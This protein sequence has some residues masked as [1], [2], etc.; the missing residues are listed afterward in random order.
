MGTTDTDTCKRELVIEVP[1]ESV[2]REVERVTL[3]FQSRARVSGF[4][5]GKTPLSL[6]RQRFREEIRE[7]VLHRLVPEYFRRRLEAEKLEAIAG[8]Q[9]EDVHLEMETQEPLRFKAVFEVMPSFEMKDYTGLEVEVEEPAVSEEEVEVALKQ[10]QEQ[11]A[12]FAA[13]EDRPLQDGDFAV[14]SMEG[15][16]APGEGGNKEGSAGPGGS[17]AGG[18]KKQRPVG[19]AKSGGGGGAV[20]VDDLLCEIGGADTLPAFTENLHGAAPGEERTFPVSYPADFS[21]QRLA[22][23][24]LL[25]TVRVNAVK[26]KQVPE[27]NDDFARDLGHFTALEEVRADIRRNLFDQKRQR[28]EHEAKERL[29]DRLIELHPCPVPDSLVDK[30]VQSR[31]ERTVRQLAAQGVNPARLNLDWARLRS[32]QREGALRDV[33]AG[34]ILERIAEREQI[35]VSGEEMQQE[36]ERL[37]R[38][39]SRGKDAAALRARLTTEGVT[40]R[41]K[42][43]LR[44]DK[45]L[46]FVYR[47]AKKIA[48]PAGAEPK[49]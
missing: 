42:S 13:V 19:S 38:Q 7:E 27:L 12:T 46:D 21:D 11:E 30:Q 33:R 29:L 32:S 36:I 47:Q 31:M 1:A 10:L 16:P 41:I 28:A 34:L 43:R 39:A 23:R 40:D 9:I 18:G 6:I 24:T 5:P 14:V 26:Q 8:P 25:Y 22:G 17:E 44:T 2:Q 45:T 49:T 35:Q 3:V 48:R 20:K 4:R 15:K 37:V